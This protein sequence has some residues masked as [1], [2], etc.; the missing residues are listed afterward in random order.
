MLTVSTELWLWPWL[1]E[2]LRIIGFSSS[3]PSPRGLTSISL[4]ADT[5]TVAT[6]A[7]MI[8]S[9]FNAV[10]I[11]LLFKVGVNFFAMRLQSPFRPGPEGP[12]QKGTLNTMRSLKD[13]TK[14][15]RACSVGVPGAFL[16][17]SH[18]LPCFP[19]IFPNCYNLT[20]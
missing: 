3:S 5:R 15:V 20:T 14:M 6:N 7:R 19:E 4:Q 8:G 12:G 17:V 9:L 11:V 13:F 2:G 18:F 16:C 10:F 1:P